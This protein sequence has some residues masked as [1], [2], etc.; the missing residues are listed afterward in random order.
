MY[1]SFLLALTTAF[2]YVTCCTS[3]SGLAQVTSDGTLSTTITSPDGRNFTI[4]NG[5]RAG[6]NLFH[7]FRDFSVPTGGSAFFNNA[8][9]VQNIFGRVTG[10][11][12]S[13]ID[14]LIR[15]NGSAN[16]FLLN[17]SGILFGPNARLNIGGS[18]V[19]STANHV[20]F[21][22]GVQ[23][24]T[25]GATKSPL[26]TMSVPI[27][28]QL[29]S[30]S[31]P[32]TVQ[33]SGY[34]LS[35]DRSTSRYTVNSASN[36]RVGSG[37]NLALIGNGVT[38]NG[39]RVSSQQAGQ[40]E[41]GGV[42]NG[43]VNFNLANWDWD[44]SK[45]S[46]YAD[47]Q[48]SQA[49]ID[50]ITP[51]GGTI[52]LQGRDVSLQSDS[53]VVIQ[54]QSAQP[55]GGI[56]INATRTFTS[57]GTTGST[58]TG[59]F[60]SRGSIRSTPRGSGV[61]AESLLG[62]AGNINIT[63]QQVLF[64]GGNGLQASGLL[65]ESNNIQVTATDLI[66]L[67]SDPDNL[68]DASDIVNLGQG[69][70]NAGDIILTTDR[71]MVRNGSS[72]STIYRGDGQG[73]DIW[74]NARDV[75]VLGS[76]SNA[77]FGIGSY[78]SSG[79]IGA[80]NSGNL[81]INAETV[82]VRGGA[83]IDSS[84]TFNNGN[85]GSVVVNASESVEVTGSGDPRL[86]SAIISSVDSLNG[87]YSPA[88][89]AGNVTITTPSLTISNGAEVSV[90][91]DGTGQ[92]GTLGIEADRIFLDQGQIT[93]STQSGDGGDIN[94]RIE[95]VLLA[96]HGS[97]ISAESSG[98]GDGGHIT[99]AADRVNLR[100]NSRISTQAQ[101]SG[102][103]GTLNLQVGQLALNRG[104]IQVESQGTGNAGRLAIHANSVQLNN[105]SLIN[106]STRVGQGGDVQLQVRNT[107]QLN[108]QSQILANAQRSGRGGNVNIAATNIAL[109]NRSQISTNA[110]G[111]A[112]G[113]ELSLESDRLSL[114]S[115][116]QITAS[117]TGTGRAGS[118][119]INANDTIRLSGNNTR[120]AATS[121]TDAVAG[122][123]LLQTPDLQL[124]DRA[125]VSVSG[126]GQG[127]AGNLT[128]RANTIQLDR[129]AALRADVAGGDQGN[130][131]LQSD[132]LLLRRGSSISTNATG[133]A[134]GGNID[135]DSDFI[136]AV[137]GENSD[138]TANAENSFGGRI[139]IDATGIFG[140]EFRSQLTPMSDI[141]ASSGLG[142]AY[143]GTVTISNPDVD[144]GSNVVKL[145]EN[146]VDA[147]N[148]VATGCGNYA[149]SRFVATGRGGI[150]L[151]PSEQVA[152]DRPWSDT[153]DLSEFV[154]Q[155]QG[156]I[157]ETPA[158][159]TAAPTAQ[160]TEITEINGWVVNEEGKV[161]LVAVTPTNEPTFEHATCS[162]ESGS[163]GGGRSHS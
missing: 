136:I 105:R 8:A 33:G 143:S 120:L 82:A 57:S 151:N 157:A 122:S 50:A 16:L 63:G 139:S 154:H 92:G 108:N 148:Q 65:A 43:I 91:N 97:L 121:T 147:S 47:I 27:G 104:Q 162:T 85:A 36:L 102:N 13:N 155:E 6:N 146:V 24:N 17:P 46:S 113:G 149:N 67:E 71:L 133:T 7:S 72:I 22:D 161:N 132:T 129:Q 49:L 158:V 80:G 39:G 10:G 90:R 41:L 160:I 111:T 145:P 61:V 118:L 2:V 5:D 3:Q 69:S 75:Q 54:N 109:Q 78:I 126:Q 12:I 138:I 32:I 128:V 112:V 15:T 110:Q 29:N 45:V 1:K 131:T 60:T 94:L 70:T 144:P 51:G 35:R 9:D 101:G 123:I 59:S 53:Q 114:L 142:A 106:A 117:T 163:G 73:G 66:L 103:A 58:P 11:N 137:S 74:V 95:G 14:G 153:R 140:T 68:T 84:A 135:I 48:L 56:T 159:P 88:G 37:N 130:I 115:G 44:Y 30:S 119:T 93:A 42:N 81:T 55:A 34:R 127:G 83:R 89:N 62:P 19:A 87:L 86:R 31:E 25:T 156:R 76:G 40:I 52:H 64:R 100:S 96:R 79:T 18:F 28:L 38:L 20:L 141:T 152:S 116:S 23:F 107:L 26:L 125:T 99:I 77:L 4:N 21:D 124:D 98:T 150:P 134:S